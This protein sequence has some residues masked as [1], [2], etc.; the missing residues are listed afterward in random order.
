ML[1]LISDNPN[2]M[3]NCQSDFMLLTDNSN[4]MWGGKSP[5]NSNCQFA[6]SAGTSPASAA[7]WARSESEETGA[8]SPAAAADDA[9][10][11]AVDVDGAV[12]VGACT[13]VRVL[14]AW[15]PGI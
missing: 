3:P 5:P 8:V 13:R 2:M 7:N 14:P 11:A 6:W 4:V 15:P 1:V 10:A 9:A 12:V